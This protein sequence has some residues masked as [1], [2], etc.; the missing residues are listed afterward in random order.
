VTLVEGDGERED[1]HN[2]VLSSGRENGSGVK[3][4]SIS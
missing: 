1:R 4:G 3:F 2:S